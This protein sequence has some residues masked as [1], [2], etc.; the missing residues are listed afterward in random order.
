VTLRVWDLTKLNLFNKAAGLM[1]A[2]RE[3]ERETDRERERDLLKVREE[4][5]S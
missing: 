2:L 1:N 5:K 4:E 3:R